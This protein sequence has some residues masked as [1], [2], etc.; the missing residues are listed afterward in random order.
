MDFYQIQEARAFGA[1]AILLIATITDG[2]QLAE[3]HH[4]ATEAGLASL[5]ECYS[6]DD[7][8]KVDFNQVK[9]FGVNNRDLNTFK[10]D[11]HRGIDL[12]NR[13]PETTVKVSESGLTSADDIKLLRDNGIHAALIGEYFMKQ[14]DPGE[15]LT[16]LIR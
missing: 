2:S 16:Q 1:D 9:I 6:E 10:V 8:N 3:L 5:V 11:V 14:K 4:A 13:A 15:G 12:L 7:L